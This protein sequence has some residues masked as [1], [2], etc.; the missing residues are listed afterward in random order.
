MHFLNSYSNEV[1]LSPDIFCFFFL[2][3]S[4]FSRS[5]WSNPLNNCI[6][7]KPSAT[8]QTHCLV[9]FRHCVFLHG[10]LA[11][12]ALFIWDIIETDSQLTHFIICPISCEAWKQFH[13]NRF[14]KFIET[15]H[16]P[17]FAAAESII[18]VCF[19]IWFPSL[20]HVFAC[21]TLLSAKKCAS[22]NAIS[23][24][25]SLSLSFSLFLAFFSAILRFTIVLCLSLRMSI[26]RLHRNPELFALYLFWE[27]WMLCGFALFAFYLRSDVVHFG[28]AKYV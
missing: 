28:F 11:I 1:K 6:T 21:I 20:I 18:V 13:M 7:K 3:S 10:K 15:I 19:P 9:L 27:G 24:S 17:W 25:L 5:H 23:G 16:L 14:S 12:I 8:I 4:V 22:C 2:V 26:F